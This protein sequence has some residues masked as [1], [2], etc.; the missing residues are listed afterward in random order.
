M[1]INSFS[2]DGYLGRDAELKDVNG[3]PLCNFPVCV[4][5]G[6]GDKKK[7]T[8]IRCNVWGNFGSAMHPYLTRGQ[9]IS[10]QGELWVSE[11]EKE[12][13]MRYQIEVDVRQLTAPKNAGQAAS[14][15][16]NA[17]HITEQVFNE[18]GQPPLAS[19]MGDDVPF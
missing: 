12:G 16:D 5:K 2:F 8:W 14:T 19:E 9:Y 6:F 18:K 10:G 11:W 4:T 3:T 1:S 13:Q 15:L 7:E 17:R